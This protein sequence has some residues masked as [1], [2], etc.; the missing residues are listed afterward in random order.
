[1]TDRLESYLLASR[2]LVIDA[3]DD[4]LPR[5][6]HDGGLYALLRD[7]PQRG[8]KMLR[9]ALCLAMGRA[10]GASV[11]ALLPTA[12]VLE[13][14][15]SAFLIHDD[16]EDDSEIRRGR[17]TLHQQ[18]GIPIAMHVGDA[19]LAAALG[20]LLDN[21]DVVGLGP[22]LGL[23]EEVARMARETAEGQMMELRLTHSGQWDL[24]DSTYLRL[25]HKKTSWYSFIT[26]LRAAAIVAREPSPRLRGLFRLGTLL[27]AA[28]Q[29]RDDL[30]SL[31]L[32]SEET[33][34]DTLGD[35]WEGKHT[36]ILSHALRTASD[37]DRE[38]ALEIL[39]RRRAQPLERCIDELSAAGE[40][41][42]AGAARLRSL[43]SAEPRRRARDGEGVAVLRALIERQR[44]IE[45]ARAMAQRYSAAA[46]RALE[47]FVGHCPESPDV[48]FLRDLVGFVGERRR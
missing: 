43:S 13:M 38:R 24:S 15:H 14:Y 46:S 21:M 44:S 42:R 45:Y 33:G 26:P 3:L 17:P 22:S 48:R 25:V 47:E 27:G 4:V 28:F 12:V 30:L 37:V 8:G 5:S 29:I 11:D 1:M 19:M 16:V 36:M 40:L 35:L 20:P 2:S 18:H 10:L 39:R 31:E 7:Y 23:L 34:K 6:P 9:P 32:G 41:S